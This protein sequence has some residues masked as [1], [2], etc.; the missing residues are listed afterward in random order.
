MATLTAEAKNPTSRA[1]RRVAP[2]YPASAVPSIT[3]VRV[4][5]GCGEA[6]LVNISTSGVLV[7]TTTK[8][9]T[10]TPVTITFEGSFQRGA[11]KGRVAR[12]VVADIGGTVALSY[13][14]AIAFNEHILFWI[15]NEN[16]EP[17]LRFD[18][19]AAPKGEW[20]NRW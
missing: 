18:P 8:V 2:R 19:A 9:A 6:S 1:E 11:I 12:C 3:G 7:Q 16:G 4:S 13:H 10:G 15:E 20:V 5:P 14:I 17:V